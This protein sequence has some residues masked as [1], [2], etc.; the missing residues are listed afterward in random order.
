MGWGRFGSGGWWER[1]FL[2][3]L[4]LPCRAKRAGWTRG[5]G[6]RFDPSAEMVVYCDSAPSLARFGTFFFALGVSVGVYGMGREVW[7]S[8]SGSGG[9]WFRGGRGVFL[10]AH[11]CGILATIREGYIR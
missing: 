11:A 7:E 10:W 1:R 4:A 5:G 8:G 2:P 9:L 3:W 6:T